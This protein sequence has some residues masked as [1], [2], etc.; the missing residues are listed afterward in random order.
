MVSTILRGVVWV[1]L[2]VC[3]VEGALAAPATVPPAAPRSSE[4]GP[5][6]AEMAPIAN[7]PRQASRSRRAKVRG[8]VEDPLA[9]VAKANAVARVQP[10]LEAYVNAAQVYAFS[11]GALYQVYATP[12]RVT[13]IV[14]QAQE[15]LSET[16]PVAAGDTTRWVIGD[17]ESGSGPERRVH[18]LVKPTRAD[19]LTNLVI[20]TD[21]RTYHLELRAT[22]GAYM[23][24]VSWRYP[25]DEA[26][27]A[28]AAKGM[29]DAKAQAE[30]AKTS[31]PAALNFGYRISG[32]SGWRPVRVYDDGRQ[33][34]I[35]FPPSVA[36]GEM[37]P[38]FVGSA[39]RAIELVNY[40]VQGRRMIVD[41]IFDAAELRLGDRRGHQRVRIERTGEEGP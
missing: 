21:R 20:N 25:L 14:L 38:I 19:L 23:A 2:A 16:G 8:P 29:A 17:T 11:D 9:R 37:P 12:G 31:E 27:A 5:K 34:F 10:R 4:I 22:S 24:A 6:A 13:D 33:T 36:Q 3:Q 39:G 30:R 41:R 18:I 32:R 35:E 28:I 15:N 1:A 26:R 40:R 7:S